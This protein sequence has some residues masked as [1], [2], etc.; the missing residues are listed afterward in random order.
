MAFQTHWN[1]FSRMVGPLDPK[2]N[3]TTLDIAKM[4]YAWGREDAAVEQRVEDERLLAGQINN[5]LK[6]DD[7]N[8]GQTS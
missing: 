4:A 1:R 8:E 3:Q 2:M 7:K 6:G 5:G